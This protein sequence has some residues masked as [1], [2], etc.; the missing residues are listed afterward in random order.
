MKALSAKIVL[1]LVSLF[2]LGVATGY[3]VGH[4]PA[5]EAVISPANTNAVASLPT[6]SPAVSAAKKWRAQRTEELK[7]QLNLTPGQI[8]AVE[9]QFDELGEDYQNLRMETRTKMGEAIARMNKG[10]AK[11]LT[12]E[13]RRLFWAHLKAKAQGPGS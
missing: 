6:N 2:V 7:Q 3:V 8:A 1:S 4:R 11:E 13:Q 12:P 9:K 10:I 5:G